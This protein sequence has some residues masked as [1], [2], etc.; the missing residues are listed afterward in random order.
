[1][2]FS[3]LSDVHLE[4]Y[5]PH[6]LLKLLDKIRSSIPERRDILLLCG[7]IGR[8][9]TKYNYE[10]Y[11]FFLDTLSPYYNQ[12]LLIAG[13]HEYFGTSLETGNKLLSELADSV[14]NLTFLNNSSYTIDR[15][16]KRSI[17]IL[18]TT[19]WGSANLEHHKSINDFHQIKNF[20]DKPCDYLVKHQESK[21]WLEDQLDKID[22][23]EIVVMTHHQPSHRLIHPKYNKYSHLDSFYASTLDYMFDNKSIKYWTYGHTHTSHNGKLEDSDISFIC[24]PYGY[25]GENSKIDYFVNFL[26][27]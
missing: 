16:N 24:N 20:I 19:L 4:H 25:P 7:D 11:R 1:M 17:S 12:M 15:E 10:S 6:K 14:P 23:H 21:L 9:D 13:N 18:G 26:V 27:D 3:L 5:K 22:E 8:V 2:R